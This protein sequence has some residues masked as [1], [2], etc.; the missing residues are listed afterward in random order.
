MKKKSNNTENQFRV[1]GGKWRS[2]RLKFL[3]NAQLRPTSDRVRETLFNW[4][5]RH[6]L[7]ARCL[8]LFAGS[9]AL[10][11]EGLSRR[12]KSCDFVDSDPK[13]IQQIRANLDLLKVDTSKF[14]L[15]A[16]KAQDFLESISKN[17]DV[18]FLDPPFGLNMLESIIAKLAA[19]QEAGSYVY[20][21]TG[22]SEALSKLPEN[23]RVI[24]EKTAGQVRYHLILVD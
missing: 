11:F 19:T 9:G 24:R 15:H 20:I 16:K 22:K 6:I 5:G 21:E 18:V 12:A 3:P 17:Y 8:D 10:G 7:Q 14:Q 4:L 13:C 1:I 23:W 2:R